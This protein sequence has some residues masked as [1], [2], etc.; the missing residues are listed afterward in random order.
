MAE[1]SPCV[2]TRTHAHTHTHKHLQS[3]IHAYRP[4]IF[5]RRG[6]GARGLWWCTVTSPQRAVTR[7]RIS[8]TSSLLLNAA[9]SFP[10]CLHIYLYHIYL[11]LLHVMLS[12]LL[13]AAKSFPRCVSVFVSMCLCLCLCVCVFMC[14]CVCCCCSIVVVVF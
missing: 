10:R 13:N 3:Y 2:H 1:R 7:M 8:V 9:K 11:S 4:Q 6:S 14:V 12:A 5:A